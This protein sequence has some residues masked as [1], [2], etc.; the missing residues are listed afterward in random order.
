[1][2]TFENEQSDDIRGR[3]CYVI[4]GLGGNAENAFLHG[5]Y[6]SKDKAIETMIDL[7]QIN[8]RSSLNFYSTCDE[9]EEPIWPGQFK[10]RCEACN[11]DICEEC[12]GD[13]SLKTLKEIYHTTDV[14]IQ[15]T[16]VEGCNLVMC[17]ATIYEEYKDADGNY[18]ELTRVQNNHGYYELKEAR[19]K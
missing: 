10:Y 19:I 16:G 4:Y 13:Y 6:A 17:E 11:Y 14:D 3:T 12:S 8:N 18:E 1:M 15:L 2:D 5:V 7:D 9:C